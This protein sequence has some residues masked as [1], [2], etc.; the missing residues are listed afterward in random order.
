MFSEF[1]DMR[2]H[3]RADVEEIARKYFT[4]FA[5]LWDSF[6]FFCAVSEDTTYAF[7]NTSLLYWIFCGNGLELPVPDCCI[8]WLN[9]KLSLP[10]RFFLFYSTTL[11][12][13]FSVHLSVVHCLFFFFLILNGLLSFSSYSANFLLFFYLDLLFSSFFI[14]NIVVILVSSLITLDDIYWRL[15][16]RKAF[17]SPTIS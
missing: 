16:D 8:S 6:F 17:L 4:F 10:S 7:S 11:T 5:K 3:V 2:A 12:L 1:R 13:L 14:T 15:S 9:L